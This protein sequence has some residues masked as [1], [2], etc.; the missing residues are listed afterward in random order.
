M[1]YRHPN[2]PHRFHTI[3]FY[4]PETDQ[5]QYVNIIASA[6][7]CQATVQARTAVIPLLKSTSVQQSSPLTTFNQGVLTGIITTE[8]D[9]QNLLKCY[10]SNI[11]NIPYN[12]L[13]PTHFYPLKQEYFYIETSESALYKCTFRSS[14][15]IIPIK[16]ETSLCWSVNIPFYAQKE[17]EEN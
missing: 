4:D 11:H 5:T 8:L 9:Y 14:I 7:Q 16:D 1:A 2:A 6:F 17:S 12:K 13:F 3:S 15:E 10:Y